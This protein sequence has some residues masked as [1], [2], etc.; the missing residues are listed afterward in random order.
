MISVTSTAL[1][2]KFVSV[3]SFLLFGQLRDLPNSKNDFWTHL[4]NFNFYE[5]LLVNDQ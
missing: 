5:H 3:A 4:L 1:Q 2:L